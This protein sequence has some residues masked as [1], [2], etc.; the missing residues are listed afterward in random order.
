MLSAFRVEMTKQWRRPRTYVAL[1][2][3]VGIPVLLTVLV[4]SNP[5]KASDERFVYLAT[6]TGLFVPVTALRVMSRF[7]L[8]IIVALFAGDAVASEASWGNLRALLVR[9]IGRSR[10]LAAKATS[11]ALLG[12]IATA[13]IVITGLVAGGMAFGW[14]PLDIGGLLG[15]GLHFSQGELLRNLALSTFYVFWSLT[16]VIALG[17]MISTMTDSPA[18]AIFSGV[19]LYIVSQILDGISSLGSVRYVLPTHYFDTWSDLFTRNGSTNGDL[20][21]GLLLPLAYITIFGGVAWWWFR[22]KDIL[23]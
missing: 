15:P 13:L 16:S 12:L 3:T 17:V 11:A 4:K 22:R 1:A 8:V 10:L 7:L 20:V 2:V 18:A 6:Q 5:P 21:R 19:G 9:P 23:S 14:H